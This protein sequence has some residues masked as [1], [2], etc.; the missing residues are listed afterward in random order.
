LFTAALVTGPLAPV[1]VLALAT[2]FEALV[3]G[4]AD[5]AFTGGGCFATGLGFGAGV[6]GAGAGGDGGNVSA[7]SASGTVSGTAGAAAIRVGV[8]ASGATDDASHC[9]TRDAP[10]SGVIQ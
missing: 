10:G 3:S 7:V 4:R 6:T 8:F 5:A 2:G 9:R 1:I